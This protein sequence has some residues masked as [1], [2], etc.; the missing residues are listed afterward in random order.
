MKSS[1]GRSSASSRRSIL[2]TDD[3]FMEDSDDD[4]PKKSKAESSKGK[5]KSVNPTKSLATTSQ[6]SSSFLTAA[7]QREQGKK[8]EKKSAEDPYSFLQDVKDVRQIFQVSECS[9]NAVSRKMAV[10]LE[11]PVTIQEHCLFLPQLGK[12]LHHLKNRYVI[13]D[14]LSLLADGSCS[15]GRSVSMLPFTSQML[16]PFFRLNKTTMIRY[17]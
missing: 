6:G 11:K 4:K 1:S 10:S 5:A 13:F 3:D 17:V 9:A 2:S 7:E 15:S 12:N 14:C 16:R 8:N